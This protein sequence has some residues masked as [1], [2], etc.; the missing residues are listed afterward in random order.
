MAA[1]TGR[2]A[3]IPLI[4]G[5]TH[6]FSP[7][8]A[9]ILTGVMDRCNLR[10][11]NVCGIVCRGGLSS[12]QNPLAL[13]LKLLHPGTVYACGGLCYKLPPRTKS[14]FDPL[15]QAKRLM[16]L[17]FDGIKMIEGKPTAYKFTGIAMNDPVYDEYYSW[18]QAE[19]IPVV[20]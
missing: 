15:G 8:V 20:F 17:G 13:L 5:H 14:N 6:C 11:F 3:E 12:I 4:D 16:A 9:A 10:A 1:A 18:I 2:S 7:D 19:R